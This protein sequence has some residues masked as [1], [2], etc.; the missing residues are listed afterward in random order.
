[1]LSLWLIPG[2]ALI[3]PW[4]FCLRWFRFWSASPWVLREEV[5]SAR[6]GRQSLGLATDDGFWQRF[7][8]GFLIEAGDA[9]RAWGRGWRALAKAIDGPDVYPMVSTHGGLCLFF[10]FNQGLPALAKVRAAGFDVQLVHQSLP[11]R[12]RGCGYARFAYLQLRLAMVAKVTANQGIATGGARAQIVAAIDSGRMVFVAADTPPRAGRGLVE[13]QFPGQRT[14]YWR[15]GILKLAHGLERPL[16]CFTV[17]VDW[18]TGRRQLDFG[19]LPAKLDMRQLTELL[20]RRFLASLEAQPE[21]WFYWP[22]PHVFLERPADS[23]IDS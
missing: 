16:A 5:A 8:F 21:L 9:F 12:P 7:R 14:A 19:P 20:N 10:N 3:V 17:T 2:V 6:A 1:L 13:I 18:S 22:A 4:R 11:T 23:R 15:S